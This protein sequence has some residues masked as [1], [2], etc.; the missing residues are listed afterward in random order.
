MN[1]IYYN[2][3]VAQLCKKNGIIKAVLL[4]YIYNYHKTNARKGAGHPAQISLAEFRYQYLHEDKALWS[5]S[6]IHEMLKALENQKHLK[7]T[8]DER[9]RPV[10]SVAD[11]VA[12]DLKRKDATWIGFD[13]GLACA[14]NI[15]I[16]IIHRFLANV[17]EKS[18][19]HVAYSLNV[20]EIAETNCISQA[21]IYRVIKNLVEIRIFKKVKSPVRTKLRGVS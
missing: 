17:I 7:V 12:T 3:S 5:E 8:R 20:K 6:Y 18:P 15:Y 14:S 1:L 19:D 11:Q 2:S 10:Y 9:N 4:N 21:E 16:A 13:L